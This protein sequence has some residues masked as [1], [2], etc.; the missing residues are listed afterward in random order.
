M[1]VLNFTNYP[2]FQKTYILADNFWIYPKCTYNCHVFLGIYCNTYILGI[3][4]KY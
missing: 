1:K 4:I 3:N 2:W